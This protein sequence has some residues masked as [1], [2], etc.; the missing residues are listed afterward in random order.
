M[1]Y[2]ECLT[3]LD[4]LTDY[5]K[6]LHLLKGNE[7]SLDRLRIFLRSIGDPQKELKIVHVAGSK[8]KGSISMMIAS[9]LRAAGHKVGLYTSPHLHD[10]RE[11]V[12]II[13]S[14]KIEDA[15]HDPFYGMIA[16]EDFARHVQEL[17]SVHD[18]GLAE[19]L[20]PLTYFEFLTAL[21]FRYFYEQNVDGVI[22]ETGLGGRLDATNVADSLVAVI[23]PISLEHTNILGATV[24]EIAGEKAAIIKPTTRYAVMAFQDESVQQVIKQRCSASSVD[25]I[26]VRQAVRILFKDGSIDGQCVD[27]YYGKESYARVSLLSPGKHQAE[28]AAA[29]LASIEALKKLGFAI[30]KEAVYKGLAEAVWPGRFEIIRREPLIILDAAHNGASALALA[31]TIRDYCKD[32]KVIAVIGQSVDKDA[33]SFAAALLPVVSLV[34]WACADH[35][36]A[37]PLTLGELASLFP[38]REVVVERTVRSACEQALNMAAQDDV[39]LITG[40]VFVVA[41]AR[42]FLLD[43]KV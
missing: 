38:E 27:L 9:I 16:Q 42:K 30:S 36:R 34:I 23:G 10:V 20:L 39:L 11:R 37:K 29:A 19:G 43:N 40:S 6:H 1:S 31:G 15:F 25:L 5:A 21:A 28:N 32:R 17:R 22:L 35:P 2:Q 14:K 24:E 13:E 7:F 18:K 8:G 12:R 26:D 3:Y 4:S 41:E 33:A